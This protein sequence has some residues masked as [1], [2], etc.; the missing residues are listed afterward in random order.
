MIERYY[1]IERIDGIGQS[2][3]SNRIVLFGKTTEGEELQVA[4]PSIH[5]SEV[6]LL[7]TR[8]VAK[9]QVPQGETDLIYTQAVSDAQFLPL[10]GN[11]GLALVIKLNSGLE[12]PLEIGPDLCADLLV[13]LRALL[14]E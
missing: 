10:G 4:F 14:K 9:L 11:L 12:V 8:A 7:M 3:E 1:E 2:R 5:A 6:I 13:Q